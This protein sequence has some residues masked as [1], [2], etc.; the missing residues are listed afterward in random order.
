MI[1]KLKTINFV[2]NDKI[3]IILFKLKLNDKVYTNTN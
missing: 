3:L 1:L 2:H